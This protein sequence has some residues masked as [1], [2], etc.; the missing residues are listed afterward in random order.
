MGQRCPFP[1]RQETVAT[2][3]SFEDPL[4][5]AGPNS[6]G[7]PWATT[8][9]PEAAP[10][11]RGAPH[12]A[13][14]DLRGISRARVAK[15]RL[16]VETALA[17]PRILQHMQPVR[18]PL[19]SLTRCGLPGTIP[20]PSQHTHTEEAKGGHRVSWLYCRGCKDVTLG[21]ATCHLPP[22]GPWVEG[23]DR[24]QGLPWARCCPSHSSSPHSS[25][26]WA[27]WGQGRKG[28]TM[29]TLVW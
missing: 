5:P 28:P 10:D 19:T 27:W 26:P 7:H 22:P 16:G 1:G 11:L 23:G 25:F 14:A 18:C 15:V 17:G 6:P 9:Q 13:L 2:M 3:Q 12:R 29:V 4:S 21:A 8:R 24:C 20:R